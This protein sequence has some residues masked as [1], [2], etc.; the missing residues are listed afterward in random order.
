MTGTDEQLVRDCL[1]GN[2]GAF[3]TLIEK[4]EKPIYNLAFRMAQDREDA[5]DLTHTVF[6]KAYEHLASFNSDHRFYSWLYRIAVNECLNFVERRRPA[7]PVDDR[8]EAGGRNPE[9]AAHGGEICRGVQQALMMLKPDHR[10]V[11]VL[12]HFLDCSYAEMAVV[13]EIPEKTVKSRLFTARQQLK[14]TLERRRL[15]G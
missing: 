2:R 11:L 7:E 9:D 5:R 10:A 8:L 14:E 3:A 4:Y 1:E 12:R 13:L 15:L 6:L